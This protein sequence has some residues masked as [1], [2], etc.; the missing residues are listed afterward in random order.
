MFATTGHHRVYTMRNAVIVTDAWLPQTNG[1]VTTL[2][3]VIKYLP[4]FGYK[5][6]VI[7][8][9]LFDTY[10]LPGYP[11]IEL[12]R[13]P[14]R[15]K[16]LILDAEPD[17]I[18]IAT[19]GP[20]GMVARRF[21]VRNKLPF[22]TSLHTKFPEYVNE[23]TGMPLRAGYSLIRWFH[24]AATATLCTT[25]S[26]KE[27]LQQWGLRNL[28]V[29]GRGVDTRLFRPA[30]LRRPNPKLTLLYVGRVAIEKNLEA[31]LALDFGEQD[32]ELRIVGDGPQREELQAK[33]PHAHWLGYRKGQALVDEYAHADVFV[34]PSKTD[35]FGLVMLEAMAC[36]TPVA[37]YPVTGPIDIVSNG[38]NGHLSESLYDAIQKARHVSRHECRRFAQDNSWEAV[39]RRMAASFAITHEDRGMPA[40]P[41]SSGTGSGDSGRM[42]A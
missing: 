37:A 4:D 21:C 42:A 20:L 23:R 10:P 31:L 3:T 39:A 12:A 36:G 32:V 33:Y 15:V 5:V 11:E 19:E 26:H 14:R 9:G 35:T 16:Q 28:V 27:E 17:S 38:T 22:T 29:W 25:Q 34:F 13:N 41:M 18:H 30:A 7:H 8:P 1:V 2:Q 6:T 40:L 24:K